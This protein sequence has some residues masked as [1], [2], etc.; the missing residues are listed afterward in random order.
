MT[1]KGRDDIAPDALAVDSTLQPKSM[2]GALTRNSLA[3]M[4]NVVVNGLTGLVLTRI[5]IAQLGLASYGLFSIALNAAILFGILADLG[6]SLLT[7]REM[8]RDP[9]KAAE[10]FARLT[11]TRALIGVGV[12]ALAG[13]ASYL[14]DYPAIV[15]SG[16][17][18]LALAIV[19]SGLT[20]QFG[21]Y[22]Q[23]RL[24]AVK[25]TW[26]LL[27]G[28]IARFILIVVFLLLLDGGLSSIFFGYIVGA[29]VGLAVSVW[30]AREV[31]PAFGRSALG[32]SGF[33][34]AAV[35]GLIIVL[36]VIHFR[37]DVLLLSALRTPED[38][39]AYGVAYRVFE[40]LIM[41]GMAFAA[42]FY[43]VL[44]HAFGEGDIEAA[45]RL[46]Q[47][48][49][50]G[51]AGVSLG[52]V[53]LGIV[54]APLA[55]LLLTG[56]S[57]PTSTDT[58]RVLMLCLPVIVMSPI[59]SLTLVSLNRANR[60]IAVSSVAIVLNVLLNLLLIPRYGATGAAVA[61]LV[62]ETFVLG[63]KFVLCAR[64]LAWRASLKRLRSYVVASGV[65]L[66]ILLGATFAFGSHSFTVLGML[67]V[68]VLIY[69]AL[70]LAF[71]AISWSTVLDAARRFIARVSTRR[72]DG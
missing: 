46:I 68:G 54:G 59:F 30:F 40:S 64:V 65:T 35:L 58:L 28:T 44:T 21:A 10:T 50:D 60:I 6:F 33:W 29:L 63:A 15:R 34:S 48:A 22:F 4:T 31:I 67:A 36:D 55:V 37:V 1:E 42:A 45:R 41:L 25:L 39:G 70:C 12:L 20:L 26:S 72:S 43:S 69:I 17:F 13:A 51:L 2:R 61:T 71:G 9:S 24:E 56:D 27:V 38:V 32:I 57:V 3:Q 14:I 5:I 53:P 11:T 52:L 62:S 7:V 18:F 47:R 23:A 49:F 66:V 8:N 19:L 16:L